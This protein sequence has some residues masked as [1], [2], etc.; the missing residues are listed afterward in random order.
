MFPQF[1]DVVNNVQPS[2]MFSDGEW[3]MTS[4][5]GRTPDCP[6]AEVVINDRWGKETRHTHGGYDTTEH[7][8]GLESGS[9]PWEESRGMGFSYGY[10]RMESLADYHIDRELLDAH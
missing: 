6:A 7:T 3:E 5:Q 1:K 10:N 8:A 4:E 9:H 2:I